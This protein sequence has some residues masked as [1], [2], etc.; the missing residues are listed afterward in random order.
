M[1]DALDDTL[2]L[3][4]ADDPDDL[5]G[6][7]ARPAQEANVDDALPPLAIVLGKV[8]KADNGAREWMRKRMLPDNV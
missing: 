3:T 1:V 5:N 7:P 2:R 6:R 8:A 4:L